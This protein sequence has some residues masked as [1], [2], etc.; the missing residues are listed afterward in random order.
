MG[1]KICANNLDQAVAGS[2]LYR[3][4]KKEDIKYYSN[5]CMRELE[6]VRK[7]IELQQ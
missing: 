1:I 2:A 4:D 6:N 5:E 3:V 7:K